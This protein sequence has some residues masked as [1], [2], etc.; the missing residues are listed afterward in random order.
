MGLWAK[1]KRKTD[2]VAIVCCGDP[3]SRHAWSATFLAEDCFQH[4]IYPHLFFFSPHTAKEKQNKKFLNEHGHPVWFC[5][6]SQQAG[7]EI[8]YKLSRFR[9]RSWVGIAPQVPESYSVIRTGIQ[10]LWKM[11]PA[12]DII[13]TD[14][15]MDDVLMNWAFDDL[16][17]TM[18]V[19]CQTNS[20]KI[21][22]PIGTNVISFS[23]KFK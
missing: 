7:L 5:G 22:Y 2:E 20:E 8:I 16:K 19:I 15:T 1:T 13:F 18:Q 10:F 14:M 17:H 9:I 11:R 6:S 12:R 23:E 21:L 3:N 4:L